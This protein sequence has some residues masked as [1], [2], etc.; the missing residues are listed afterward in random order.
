MN[1]TVNRA[2]IN[3]LLPAYLS[4]DASPETCQLIES[5]L[6]TDPELAEQVKQEGH[7]PF[8]RPFASAFARDPE[9]RALH[10][11][12]RAMR[13][14]TWHLIFAVFCSL[15]AITYQYGPEGFIWT[16]QTSPLLAIVCGLV[17]L[18]SW[19]AYA[20]GRHALHKGS[21]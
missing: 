15:L 18:L 17:A 7:A 16:W 12:R 19:W 14:R 8:S 5:Y 20:R 13:R 4:G 9:L 3:D 10:R 2:I 21:L 6:K 11:T 1:I